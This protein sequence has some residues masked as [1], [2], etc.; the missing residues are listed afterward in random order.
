M[1]SR[2]EILS[3]LKQE[4]VNL[5]LY[6]APFPHT[7][8]RPE[9]GPL[10][11]LPNPTPA[12]DA[13]RGSPF[14][15]RVVA[16]A[17][18]VLQRR[19]SLLTLEARTTAKIDWQLDPTHPERNGL[20]WRR[21]A[22]YRLVPA[23]DAG[24]VGDYKVI[25]ELNRLQHLPL[26]AQAFR[27][28]RQR[29]FID[30]I[31]MATASWRDQNRLMAG[32]NWV[33]ALEAAFRIL[34]WIWTWHIAGK[35]LSPDARRDILWCIEEH[36]YFLEYNLSIYH[37]PNTHLLGEALALEA[38]GALFPHFKRAAQWRRLGS[39]T[40]DQELR[41][42][43]LADGG[44]FERS[45]YYHVYALDIFLFHGLLAGRSDAEFQ[46][47]LRSMAHYLASIAGV[48]RR[49]PLIGDDDG[50]RLF[51]PYGERTK[52]C[53]AT[54][55]AAG[56]LL[57]EPAW[58]GS[59]EDAAEMAA[60]WWG[61]GALGKTGKRAEGWSEL[62]PK[63]GIAVMAAGET[64]IIVDVGPFGEISGGHSHADTLSLM[65]RRGGEEL[66]I[67][68]GTYTYILDPRER[69]FF[70]GT[71]AHNT[72]RIDGLSQAMPAGPFRWRDRPAVEIGE[73]R[74]G[75]QR[76]LLSA[77][78]RYRGLSHARAVLFVKPDLIL[79]CDRIE[80]SGGEHAIEQFWHAGVP[81]R[82]ESATRVQLGS[83]AW[84]LIGPGAAV[85][86][87]EGGE[88][89]WWSPGL[90]SKAPGAYIR[91]AERGRLPMLRWTALDLASAGELTVDAG[92][93]SYRRASLEVRVRIDV[94]ESGCIKMVE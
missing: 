25:W 66:L 85:E 26:L 9:A 8:E 24:L 55:T 44:Y 29:K 84:M 70:R 64:Q 56:V 67:D 83:D 36:A 17:E 76:D 52:F 79:V 19:F 41:I 38:A 35:E 4:T 50:G 82:P 61:A 51:H 40:L 30:E 78:C 53:R 39:Q 65:V 59:S 88:F 6:L 14:A 1:R 15:E 27:F 74:T 46:G 23:M 2:E 49:L 81:A 90:G 63:T 71:A 33:S 68:P 43:V 86:V 42:Q 20:G 69:D 58:I 48:S 62:F 94:A 18:D 57:D 22:H 87:G 11:G 12:V 89:G 21:H 80:G 77:V 32:I 31:A 93:A 10:A 73:W 16:L 47:R 7:S 54:L 5:R 45:S 37:S 72:I 91:V 13:L 75:S 92:G 60:W 28:T 3:R 34:S